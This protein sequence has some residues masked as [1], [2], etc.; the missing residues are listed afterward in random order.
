MV[1]GDHDLKCSKCYDRKATK[2]AGPPHAAIAEERNRG[3]TPDA[4]IAKKGNV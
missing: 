4:I 2:L 3:E 1:L